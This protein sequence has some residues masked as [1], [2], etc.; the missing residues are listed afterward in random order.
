MKQ[1]PYPRSF[2]LS[3]SPF[4]PGM[5]GLAD[6]P[7]P[8]PPGWFET[9][10]TNAVQQFKDIWAAFTAS[11]NTLA[12]VGYTLDSLDNSQID[13][14]TLA[15]WQSRESALE[16][17]QGS[18]DDIVAQALAKINEVES[19][20]GWPSSNLG[21]FGVDDAIVI[22]T[23]VTAGVAAVG[24]YV[25]KITTHTQQVNQLS[26]EL[27]AIGKGIISPEQLIRLQQTQQASTP[28]SGVIQEILSSV[29]PYV[30]VAVALYFGW[31]LIAK[32]L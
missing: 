7:A 5:H 24:Y 16:N 23:V 10:W 25:Y 3:P 19:K 12:T 27:Q 9:Q 1:R 21:I 28:G 26:S 15:D 17:E 13:P 31:R 22:A 4:A 14:A 6:A 11:K 30:G 2:E 29:L 18:I 20:L 32:K 8:E